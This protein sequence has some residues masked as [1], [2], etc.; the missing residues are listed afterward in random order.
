MT[1]RKNRCQWTRSSRPATGERHPMHSR[2]SRRKTRT[3]ALLQSCTTSKRAAPNLV[4]STNIL[5]DSQRRRSKFPGYSNLPVA[6]PLFGAAFLCHTFAA[7]GYTTS[8][9]LRRSNFVCLVPTH[10][11]LLYNLQ[12]TV[13]GAA[14]AHTSPSRHQREHGR[15]KQD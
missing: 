7:R 12:F 8:I 6:Q 5:Q 15:G 13:R 11:C 14:G 2:N 9:L 4:P 10:C 3:E 1:D